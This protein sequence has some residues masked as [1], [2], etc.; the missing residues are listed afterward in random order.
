MCR[1]HIPSS[2]DLTPRTNRGNVLHVSST[3][4]SVRVTGALTAGVLWAPLALL[5]ILSG[6]AS[7]HAL[8]IAGLVMTTLVGWVLAP[9]AARS[10]GLGVST[11]VTFSVLAVSSGAFLYG[12]LFALIKRLEPITAVGFGML[13]LLVLGLPLTII[14]VKLA[15]VWTVVV[16][17]LAL[18]ML[19]VGAMALLT[20]GCTFTSVYGPLSSTAAVGDQIEF[21]V[22]PDCG[23]DQMHFDIDGSLWMPTTIDP[24]DRW[25][26]IAHNLLRGSS[27][28]PRPRR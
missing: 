28:A 1:C 17:K 5:L 19:L 11:A 9:Q 2:R 23:L 12:L 27:S 8:A 3:L 25:F 21:I 26:A 22:N 15:I 6:G 13:G 20:L 14:G 16:R 24:T 7:G 4:K 18:R 10:R